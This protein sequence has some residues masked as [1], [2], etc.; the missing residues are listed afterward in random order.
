MTQLPAVLATAAATAA[1]LDARDPLAGFRSQFLLPLHADGTPAVYLC[2]NSLGL[3]PVAARDR[4]AELMGDWA[5]LAVRGHHDGPRRFMT[6]HTQLAPSLAAL[7]GAHAHEVVAMNTLTANL[8]FLMAT[9]FR[10]TRERFRILMDRPSFPSDRYAVISQLRWHGLDPA[11]ALVEVGPREGEDAVRVEDIEARLEQDGA[12]IALVLLAGVQYLNGQRLP[13]ARLT[14]AA[15]RQGCVV[16]WDLAHAIG[17]VPVE[18]HGADVDFAAWC[19]YKYLN[20]GPGAVGGAYIH[21]RHARDVDAPRLA[22]WWGHELA[23]RFRMDPDFAAEQGADGWQ[24]SNPPVLAMAPLVASLAQFDAAGFARLRAKSLSLTGLLERLL[25]EHC[26]SAIEVATPADPEQRGCQLSLRVR[27]GRDA[28]RAVFEHLM[29]HGTV[30]DWREPDI[31]RVAPA[32][33]YNSHADVVAF[34]GRL[35]DALAAAA[36]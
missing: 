13:I 11:T 19:H 16:G 25:R 7:V 2:G 22:G 9:F 30:L 35:Q 34:V 18:L 28:G 21:E 24:V 15:R 12:S 10:P 20:A 17:N 26:A 29:S 32:P 33:L 5:Q 36:P 8:H 27:A 6:Y 23:T 31:L 4:I 3:Q 14:T 1:D